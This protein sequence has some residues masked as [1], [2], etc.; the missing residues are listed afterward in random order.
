LAIPV[1]DS[2]CPFIQEETLQREQRADHVFSDPLGLGLCLGPDPAVDIETGVPKGAKAFRP[3]GTEE[4]LADEIGQEFA[5]KDFR[6][7]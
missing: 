7:P 3:F 4:L 1:A 2:S 5:G 6:Q